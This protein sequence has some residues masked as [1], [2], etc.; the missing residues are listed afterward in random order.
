YTRT[1]SY[2]DNSEL[3]SE[4]G[5]PTGRV[6][7]ILNN[8]KDQLPEEVFTARYEPPKTDGSGRNRENLRKAMDILDAAGYKTGTDGL[9]VHETTGQRLSFE[10]IDANPMFERWTLPFIANLKKIG[11]EAKFRVLDPAQYQNR[12][13]DFDYDMTVMSIGQSDSPG[14]EQRDFWSSEKADMAGSRNYIG[15]KSPVIDDLIEKIIRASS[16]EE[17]V[18]YTRALDRILLAGHYVIPHWHV[19]YF[20]V[21]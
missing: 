3:A 4:S 8:Y 1:N 19:N 15:I 12:M 13:N 10:I 2:F 9:R 21:A 11:V 16:R 14:N 5:P 18:A 6:L 20:R 17:L 7:E